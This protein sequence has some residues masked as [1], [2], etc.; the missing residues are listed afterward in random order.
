MGKFKAEEEV[1]KERKLRLQADIRSGKIVPRKTET[2]ITGLPVHADVSA[3]NDKLVSD[4]ED[5]DHVEIDLNAMEVEGLLDSEDEEEEEEKLGT[6]DVYMKNPDAIA[7]PNASTS[8]S[9]T[10]SDVTLVIP[11]SEKRKKVI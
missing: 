9:L 4:D 11:Y 2:G 10:S 5:S 6:D 1:R 3:A 7:G 8:S